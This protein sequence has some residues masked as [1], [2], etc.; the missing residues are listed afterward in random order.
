MKQ[1]T[2]ERTM[3][4]FG[5]IFAVL[6]TIGLMAIVII[7]LMDAWQAVFYGISKCIEYYTVILQ[8]IEGLNMYQ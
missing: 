3:Y 1:E 2:I 4:I 5:V 8:Q 7:V 6:L